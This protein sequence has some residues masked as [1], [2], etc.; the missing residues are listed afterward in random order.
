MKDRNKSIS[1]RKL[2]LALFLMW[3]AQFG[4]GQGIHYIYVQSGDQTPFYVKSGLKTYESSGNGYLLME[5]LIASSYDLVIGYK[6]NP[7]SEWSFPVAVDNSDLAFTLARKA[8]VPQLWAMGGG[9]P[10]IGAQ[11]VSG[12]GVIKEPKK[13]ALPGTVSDDAFSRLLADV[14]DDQSIRLKPV[15]AVRENV[16]VKQSDPLPATDSTLIVNI[17]K[18]DLPASV[19]ESLTSIQKTKESIPK[20]GTGHKK[21][22]VT[23]SKEDF[24][25]ITTPPES[26]STPR[27]ETQVPVK[28]DSSVITSQVP[29]KEEPVTAEDPKRT[30]AVDPEESIPANTTIN[31]PEPQEETRPFVLRE[32][33]KNIKKGRK[34]EEEPEEATAKSQFPLSL[35]IKKTLQKKSADGI[36]LIYVDEVSPGNKE[37][38]RILIPAN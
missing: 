33:V 25:V 3:F 1:P 35:S 19:K 23:A 31:E 29:A 15:I 14:V 20:V 37:T 24:A 32:V 16:V 28:Q 2:V 8:G 6:N 27:Q 13:D 38:I 21:D 7:G 5:G 18:P 22:S 30:A 12:F 11:V 17:E 36:E 26:K 10:V 9:N 34:K 4:F